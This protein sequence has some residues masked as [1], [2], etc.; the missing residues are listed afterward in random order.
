MNEFDIT[1][2]QMVIVGCHDPYKVSILVKPCLLHNNEQV[3]TWDI[4]ITLTHIRMRR[5]I[6]G[7]SVCTE[8]NEIN[9]IK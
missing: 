2:A 7:Y 3:E 6:W 9:E 1:G 5:P 4:F 8:K